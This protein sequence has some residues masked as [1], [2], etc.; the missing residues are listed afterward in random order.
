MLKNELEK[1]DKAL[2]KS[3]HSEGNIVSGMIQRNPNQ[4]IIDTES[5]DHEGDQSDVQA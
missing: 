5:R 3:R 4:S 1:K 2:S